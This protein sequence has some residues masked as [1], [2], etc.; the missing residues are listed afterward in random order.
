MPRLQVRLVDNIDPRLTIKWRFEVKY[1]RGRHVNGIYI[2]DKGGKELPQDHLKIPLSG[3]KSLP[4]N[5]DWN[6]YELYKNESFFGGNATIFFNICSGNECLEKEHEYRFQIGGENPDEKITR[7]YIDLRVPKVAADHHQPEMWY[8]YAIAKEETKYEA[9]PGEAPY[10]AQFLP[11]GWKPKRKH[12]P[13]LQPDFGAPNWHDDG[14][15]RTPPGKA[16]RRKPGGYGLFQVTGYADKE[17]ADVP[18]GVIW[19]WQKNVDAGLEELARKQKAAIDYVKSVRG[20]AGKPIPSLKICTKAGDYVFEEHGQKNF[21]DLVTMKRYNG[22]GC[23]RA[24]DP[25][26]EPEPQHFFYTHNIPTDRDFLYYSSENKRYELSR[27]NTY[28]HPFVYVDQ[29]CLEIEQ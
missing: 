2:F 7:H 29:V 8:A 11:L 15:Y 3:S 12:K 23:R 26:P 10:Y 21:T 1:I 22:I 27:Y 4:A 19:N 9:G 5:A 6:L 16:P 20:F 18:R 24:P 25:D 13:P 14:F 28:D 17:D